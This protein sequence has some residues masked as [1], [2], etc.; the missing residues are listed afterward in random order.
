MSIDAYLQGR[1]ARRLKHQREGLL[2]D[3][4]LLQAALLPQVPDH[5][6]DLA[7]SVGYRP[8]QGLAAGGDDMSNNCG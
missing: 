8:A 2:D 3:V 6:G 5:A 4:G 7:V 1:R